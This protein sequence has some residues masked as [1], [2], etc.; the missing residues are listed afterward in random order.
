M[1]E[2]KHTDRVVFHHSLTDEGNVDTFR[3]YHTKHNK[4]ED[5]GYHFV[6]LKDG[7]LE[8]GRDIKYIG[9]HAQGKNSNSIGICLVGN[10]NNYEPSVEQLDECLNI[11]HCLCRSYSKNLDIDF[12]RLEPNP[13]PGTMFDR[14]D[15]VEIVSRGRI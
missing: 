13:C 8:K 4:W 12:H 9:A 5:V 11:F 15:F 2:R 10:F 14:E 7:T 6:I 3:D 1:V